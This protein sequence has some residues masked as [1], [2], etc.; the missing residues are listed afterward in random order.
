MDGDIHLK[1]RAG[2]KIALVFIVPVL[3]VEG[4]RVR[5]VRQA[6][7]QGDNRTRSTCI[8]IDR[9]VIEQCAFRIGQR[10]GDVG[11][12][13]RNILK[14]LVLDG[15]GRVGVRIVPGRAAADDL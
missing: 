4:E 7:R 14:R 10:G 2:G 3:A 9:A 11:V 13:V 12:G 6:I 5:T 15:D 1:G 8:A